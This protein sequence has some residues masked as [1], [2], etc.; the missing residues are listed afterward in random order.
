MS[1]RDGTLN[2]RPECEEC[3][4]GLS[5]GFFFFFF[6][7]AG[8]APA[9]RPFQFVSIASGGKQHRKKRNRKDKSVAFRSWSCPFFFVVSVFV[10]QRCVP[11]PPDP[12][13]YFE[14]RVL[15]IPMYIRWLDGEQGNK[16]KRIEKEMPDDDPSNVQLVTYTQQDFK[17]NTKAFTQKP[18]V[19]SCWKILFGRRWQTKQ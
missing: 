11:D 5:I 3:N 4:K 13:F 7:P 16:K 15:M 6:S 9:Y 12:S 14:I 19:E 2:G 18:N 8:L 17:R 1:S 10:R